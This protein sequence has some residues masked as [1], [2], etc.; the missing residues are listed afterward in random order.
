MKQR[1]WASLSSVKNSARPADGLAILLLTAI[2][3]YLTRP[4]LNLG[5]KVLWSDLPV[6]WAWLYWLKESIFT[7]HQL[8]TWSPMWMGGMPYFGMVPPA[9]FYFALPLYLIAGNAPG[10]YNLGVVIMFCLSAV[11]MYLYLKHLSTHPLLSFLGAIIYIVLPV[12]ISTLMV[13]GLF[14]ILCGY[15]VAPLVLLF[16]D[17]FLDHKRSL[18]LIMLSLLLIFVAMVQIEHSFL[19]LFF[20]YLPYVM[21][22]LFHKKVG[23]RQLLTFVRQHKACVLLVIVIILIPI[24]FYVPLLAERGNFKGLLP[25]E[26]AAGLDHYTFKQFSDTFTA[27]AETVLDSFFHPAT[28][29]YSGPIVLVILLAATFFLARGQ[30]GSPRCATRVFPGHGHGH[31]DPVHGR[32]RAA[33]PCGQSRG[34]SPG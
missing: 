2:S 33:V 31:A 16:T 27:K 32:V 1:L 6:S 18:D 26:I 15:A 9:G 34:S 7:F 25:E 24:S 29:H 19:F 4:L 11:S 8:P 14:E 10:A 12:S 17:R 20:F 5:T 21:F 13:H 30:E 23:L 28:E 3:L 22:A